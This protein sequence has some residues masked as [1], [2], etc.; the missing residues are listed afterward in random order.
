MF[1]VARGGTAGIEL[2][3]NT[4]DMLFNTTPKKTPFVW[5]AFKLALGI[6]LILF[7]LSQT[8][9]A[10]LTRTLQHANLTWLT[11]SII[12]FLL[13]TLLKVLQYHILMRNDASYLQVLHLIV[14]QNAIS[15]YFLTGAGIVTYFTMTRMEHE[16]KTSRSATIFLLTKA[17]DLIA[18][19]L[20]LV[21]S[22][23]LL[24]FHITP[25]RVPLL[26]AL[27]FITFIIL[28]FFLTV[29]LRQGFVS[30]VKR[31]LDRVGVSRLGFVEQGVEYLH[32]LAAMNQVK[33]LRI[34]GALILCSFVYLA[35]SLG[36]VY[37]TY[38]VFNL[39]IT[40]APFIFV[41]LVIQL[42]SYIPVSVLGGLGITET[43]SLYL[44]ELFGI[45]PT[46]LTPVLVSA[47]V[48]FYLLNLLPL[49]YLPIYELLR[50]K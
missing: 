4:P 8:N 5:S 3:W 29:F 17:G 19:W 45:S 43:T 23:V 42:V 41:S 50:K 33:V 46:T 37:T 1:S 2:R 44:F 15:N 34:L 30:L 28:T 6:G 26:V 18:I 31:F 27:A 39:H 11:V 7:V 16:I 47:R 38:A 20:T 22:T 9:L 32:G 10:D 14:W 21:A 40:P 13:T 24:W 48:L 49:I 12:L 25:V 36:W 35:V